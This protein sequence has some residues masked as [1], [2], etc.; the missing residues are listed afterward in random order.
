MALILAAYSNDAAFAAENVSADAGLE[1][2][3]N[4][5]RRDQNRGRDEWRNPLDTLSFFGIEPD[6]TIAE[7]LP[8][9][10]GW[11]SQILTP[12]T[13][14]QG[15]LIGL[16]YPESLFRQMF[17]TW[18]ED[19][20]EGIGADLSQMGRY[21]SVE[22]VDSAQPI[23]GYAIDDIPDQENGQADA[24]LFFRAMH[25]LF[26]FDE[27]II[28]TALSETYD[29]LASGGVA[30][31]V[32]HRAPEDADPGFANGNNGYLKQSDVVAAFERA[33]FVLEEASEI[34][35]NPNDPADSFVWRLPPTTTDN[36]DTQ[37]IGESDRMTLRFRKP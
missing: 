7:V 4:H 31:V 35:A 14:E 15:R 22:G 28:D 3:I 18:N 26:R 1:A 9:N 25:H 32:Q 12:L 13:A 30:G 23:V 5:E 16:T 10:G 20:A 21:L 37:A 33:G 2:V 24:V 34:N 17:S 6:M 19:S 8:G 11:Y 36:P 27:P 29:M